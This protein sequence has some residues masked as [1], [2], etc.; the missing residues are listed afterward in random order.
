[1]IPCTVWIMLC[2]E[3]ICTSSVLFLI[4]W[5]VTLVGLLHIASIQFNIRGVLNCGGNCSYDELVKKKMVTITFFLCML[6]GGDTY[7]VSL[8]EQIGSQLTP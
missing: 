6:G 5:S 1:M 8:W 3:G 4:I 7:Y 2:W